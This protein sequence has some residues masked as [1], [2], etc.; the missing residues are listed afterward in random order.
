[1]LRATSPG[2]LALLPALVL[3]LVLATATCT[4]TSHVSHCTNATCAISL[5]G[6]QTLQVEF[7]RLE[8]DLRVATIEPDAVTLSARADSERVPPGGSATV[9]DLAVRVVSIAGRDVQ[10]QVSPA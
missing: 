10:L 1:M 2:R 9:G 4:A 6:E 7:G 8:R 3:P 5:T